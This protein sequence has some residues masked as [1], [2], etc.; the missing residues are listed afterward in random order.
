MISQADVKHVCRHK[1]II[2]YLSANDLSETAATLREELGVADYDFDATTLKKYDTLL[3]KKWISTVRL[4]KKVSRHSRSTVVF[5]A[6]K[7][8]T[9]RLLTSFS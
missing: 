7:N 2:A 9:A 1:S 4:H 6:S 8:V 3:E 5:P